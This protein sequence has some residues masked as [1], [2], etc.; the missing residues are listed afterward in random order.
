MNESQSGWEGDMFGHVHEPFPE[1]VL[2]CRLLIT[3]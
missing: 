2:M 3:G 1:G